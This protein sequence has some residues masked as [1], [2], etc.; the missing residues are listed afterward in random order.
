MVRKL[1]FTVY[2][3]LFIG[4]EKLSLHF[5]HK[6]IYVQVEFTF[7]CTNTFLSKDKCSRKPIVYKFT[8]NLHS[9]VP[10]TKSVWSYLPMK[11]WMHHS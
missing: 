6:D 11:S 7:V 3:R 9:L 1:I 4:N 10:A 5:N 8:F 2:I